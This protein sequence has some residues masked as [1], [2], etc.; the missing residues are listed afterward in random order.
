[1]SLRGPSICCLA[2]LHGKTRLGGGWQACL[3]TTLFKQTPL[4]QTPVRWR[5]GQA[6]AGALTSSNSFTATLTAAAESWPH[7]APCWGLRLLGWPSIAP[8]S[9][10]YLLPTAWGHHLPAAGEAGRGSIQGPVPAGKATL[11]RELHLPRPAGPGAVCTGESTKEWDRKSGEAM[12][13]L[14]AGTEPLPRGWF[15]FGSRVWRKLEPGEI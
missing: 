6:V 12:E 15:P 10:L 13:G 4:P 5:T 11:L 14:V 8:A 1:V 9:G 2:A 7:H 3:H